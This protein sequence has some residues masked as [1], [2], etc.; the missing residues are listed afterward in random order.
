MALIL[1]HLTYWAP[2]CEDLAAGDNRLWRWVY[3]KDGQEVLR[4]ASG[5]ARVAIT[6]LSL[7]PEGDFTDICARIEGQPKP[8][9][10][11]TVVSGGLTFAQLETALKTLI[12]NERDKHEKEAA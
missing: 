10:M 8:V 1:V 7:R 12:T 5:L 4:R 6:G 9:P 11:A 3:D 2:G